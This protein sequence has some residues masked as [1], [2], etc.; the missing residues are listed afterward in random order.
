MKNKI[1]INLI[2]TL[3]IISMGYL[4]VTHRSIYNNFSLLFIIVSFF[5]YILG[6]VKDKES[7]CAFGYIIGVV[8]VILIRNKY[9]N[10]INND[11]Y[12][13]DWFKLVFKNKIVFVNVVGNLILYVPL[14]ILMKNKLFTLL[15]LIVIL[16]L[17]QYI[18]RLGVFDIIDIGLNTVGVLISSIIY[19]IKNW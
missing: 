12:I 2:I 5:V 13:F 3:V 11:F 6:I 1:V 4:V 10:V 14:F 8:T 9:D 18:F 7:I 16:E 15:L 19:K 17:L